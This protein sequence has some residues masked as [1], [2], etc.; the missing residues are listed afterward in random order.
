MDVAVHFLP[1]ALEHALGARALHAHRD[2]GIFRLERARELLT[3]RQ[4]SLVAASISAGVT[5]SAAGA[6]ETTRVAKA[7]LAATA[8]EILS[9]LRRESIALHLENLAI[10]RL[11][12]VAHLL[13]RGGIVLH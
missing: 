8:E 12:L 5:A 10:A 6:A 9:R 11:D 2:A 13:D 3:D 1:D 4:P 7:A